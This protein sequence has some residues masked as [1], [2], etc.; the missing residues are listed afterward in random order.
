MERLLGRAQR[1]PYVVITLITCLVVCL[2]PPLLQRANSAE[3]RIDWEFAGSVGMSVGVTLLCACL[4]L[5]ATMHAAGAK[6]SYP[7]AVAA[8]AYSLTPITAILG[9]LH[10]ANWGYMGSFTIVTFIATGL[11]LPNDLPLQIFPFVFR[12]SLFL[13][14]ITLA[15]GLRTVA[16]SS[17]PL[18]L[19]MAALTIPL[20]LGS[21]IIGLTCT[22]L[23]YP[24]T[25]SRTIEF[26]G[27]FFAYPG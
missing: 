17:L 24:S 27:R 5:A 18:G 25:S 19:I 26:F 22:D 12:T 10:L 3:N 7:R 14:W 6:T 4:L 11:P 15:Y 2:A 9:V 23:L 21:F 20:I 13:A 1:P 8:L 16:K